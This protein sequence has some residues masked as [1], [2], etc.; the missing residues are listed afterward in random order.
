MSLGKARDMAA[1]LASGVWEIQNDGGVYKSACPQHNKRNSSLTR[2]G[3]ETV[4]LLAVQDIKSY[5]WYTWV[6]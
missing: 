1:G 4:I 2:E 3:T 6:V 5:A